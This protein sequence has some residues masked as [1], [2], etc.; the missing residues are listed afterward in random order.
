ML[1]SLMSMFDPSMILVTGLP[2]K[3]LGATLVCLYAGGEFWLVNS[4]YR[5]AVTKVCLF[6]HELHFIPFLGV[7]SFYCVLSMNVISLIPFTLPFTSHIS[8]NLGMCLTLWLSGLLYSFGS[9]LSKSLAHY[10]PLGSPMVL[11]PFLV[12]IE[13]ASVLIRPISLSVRLMANI[14]GGHIIMSLIEESSFGSLI[15]GIFTLLTYSLMV[16]VEMFVATVQ[17]YVLSKLLSIYWE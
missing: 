1:M 3:W 17:A 11:G 16:C 9:S 13:V 4:G 6:L 15:S 12:L 7:V 2:V 10:L 8:V 5:S 14:L